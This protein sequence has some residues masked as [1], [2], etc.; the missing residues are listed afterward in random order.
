MR[1]SHR[2]APVVFRRQELGGTDREKR[3]NGEGLSRRKTGAA[4]KGRSIL[5]GVAMER[6]GEELKD[7][8]SIVWTR[9]MTEKRKDTL[10]FQ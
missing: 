2:T 3:F 4:L 1:E 7:G 8:N 10:L 5:K 9:K 6:R